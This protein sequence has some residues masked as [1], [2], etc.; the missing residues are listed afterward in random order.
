MTKVIFALDVETGGI[1][2]K[3]NTL[4]SI[5]IEV[6]N[7]DLE[8]LERKEILVLDPVEGMCLNQGWVTHPAFKNAIDLDLLREKGV[9]LAQARVEFHKLVE[10][11]LGLKTRWEKAWKEKVVLLGHNVGTFDVNFL[12]HMYTQGTKPVDYRYRPWYRRFIDTFAVGTSLV[13]AGLIPPCPRGQVDS[14]YLFEHFE[15]EVPDGYR[16]RAIGDAVATAELYRK[17]VALLR[18]GSGAKKSNKKVVTKYKI[19]KNTKEACA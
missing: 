19:V 7:E 13:D 11:H 2:P 4:H 14:D 9:S 1:D 10:K 16:H 15:I 5:G 12:E 6:L 8:T 3:A 18:K 17:M